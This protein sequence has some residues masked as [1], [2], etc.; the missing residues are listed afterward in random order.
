MFKAISKVVWVLSLVSLLTDVASEMLYP[1]MPLYLESIGFSIVLIGALEGVAE[2]TAG[3]SKGYFG[4]QSDRRG[5]RVPFVQLGYLLSAISKPMMALFTFPAW[6][7]SARTLDR[8]G[9]GVRT[10]ARDALLSDEATP[11]TKATVFGFH[12]AL[13]TL[14]AAIGPL[15]ALIFLSVYP[16]AYRPLFFLAFAPGLLSVITTLLLKEKRRKPKVPAANASFFEFLRYIPQSSIAYRKLLAGLL[17]FALFNSSDVFLLLMLKR[18]GVS[19]TMIIGIYIF[20]N[21]VYALLAFPAGVVADRI[22]WKK[23]FVTGLGLFAIVYAGMPAANLLTDSPLN[24]YYGLFFIYGAYGAGTEGVSKAWISSVC[25]AN[26]TA[27][28][29]GT[30]ESLRSLSALLASSLAGLLWV[31]AGPETIF[32]ITAAV[33]SGVIIYF[34]FF[35]SYP[36]NKV[37][38]AAVGK[39]MI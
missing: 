23:M 32:W 33:V 11:Q 17:V 36:S 31:Y 14:G 21:L 16:G 30:Y 1:I 13:D 24:L 19:D 35:T 28:A 9:K 15:L 12:R 34:I 20:Y 4:R 29:I 5:Q 10:A 8:V 25:N 39:S 22:G 3:L 2:V 38:Q 6:V 37:E 18:Q 26:D 7:F 27:T